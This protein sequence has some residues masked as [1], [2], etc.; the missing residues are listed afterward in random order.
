MKTDAK[1][2]LLYQSGM[3]ASPAKK[4]PAHNDEASDEEDEDAETSL[5][6][7]GY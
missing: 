2:D 7:G 4:R 1:I 3:F 5:V 6:G